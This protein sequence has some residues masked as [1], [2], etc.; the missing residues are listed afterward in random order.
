MEKN[1]N[2]KLLIIS[3]YLPPIKTV[4]GVRISNFHIEAQKYFKEVFAMTTS[5]R[6]LFPKEDY[7]FD[8]SKTTEI[9]TWDL[10][11]FLIKKNNNSTGVQ[12]SKKESNFVKFLSKLSYSFPFNLFLAD[13]GLT[14]IMGGFFK[15]KRLIREQNIEVIFSSYK[16]YSDHLICFLLKKW[17]PKLTWI[18]DFRD[19]HV[20]EIRKN[21]FFPKIQKWFN[22]RVLK[23][24]DVVTTVSA[25]L[26][27]NLQQYTSKTYVLRN[28]IASNQFPLSANSFY[29][30]F[31][32]AYT[33]S[34]YPKYQSADLLLNALKNL[35]D[36]KEID[37]NKI[38]L[39]YAG[40]EKEVW[41]SWIN[42]FDLQQISVVNGFLP[43]EQA[44]EIQQK[45][46]I[47]LLLSWATEKQQGILT[48][49][50]YEY[51]IAQNPIL[52]IIKGTEDKEFENIFSTTHAGLIAY[53]KTDN[54]NLVESFVLKN[55][56]EWIEKGSV[57][58]TISK[59]KLNTF[60]WDFQMNTFI[61]H[62]E[63]II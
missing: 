24:A 2:K 1:S 35:I 50:F 39:M 54:Q 5:N 17:N 44:K 47:N 48:A 18:A 53:D 33:G 60:A 29:D 38:Q 8:D 14:Y 9:W 21:V 12:Q 13:G 43:I 56:H 40:K 41:T 20:D 57:T 15:G 27:K 16:P 62:L 6:H 10:R 49:K 63:K 19:L 42:N 23:K 32:I 45:S 7:N 31:T 37:A 34:I 55:Y 51:L 30:K 26:E 59:E 22:R 61:T 11:R 25:G 4:A 46:H 52:L 36:K 28:G 58:R 3:Y